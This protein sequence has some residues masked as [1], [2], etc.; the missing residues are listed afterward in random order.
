MHV[1]IQYDLAYFG[2][3]NAKLNTARGNVL[4]GQSH[5]HRTIAEGSIGLFNRGLRVLHIS[6]RTPQADIF[7]RQ[8]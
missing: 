1:A 4:L 5:L 7:P 2:L 8:Y 6:Q 3:N